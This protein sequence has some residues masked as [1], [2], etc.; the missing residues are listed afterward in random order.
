M[1]CLPPGVLHTTLILR[2]VKQHVTQLQNQQHVTQLQNQ[3]HVTQLQNQC[4]LNIKKVYT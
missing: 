1:T 4:C 3:Q 2:N